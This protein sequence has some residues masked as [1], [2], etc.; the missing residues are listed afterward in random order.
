MLFLSPPSGQFKICIGLVCDLSCDRKVEQPISEAHVPVSNPN[1]SAHILCLLLASLV[2]NVGLAVYL[3]LC[4]IISVMLT[5]FVH[6]ANVKPCGSDVNS[7]YQFMLV[8]LISPLCNM[9][10]QQLHSLNLLLVTPM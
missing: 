3:P 8:H 4:N 9:N 1:E 6:F 7:Q 10:I 5:Y 2:C